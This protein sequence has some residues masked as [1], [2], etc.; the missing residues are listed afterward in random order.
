MGI[1]SAIFFNKLIDSIIIPDPCAYHYNSKI[2]IGATFKMFYDINSGTG[3][4]PEPSDFN[5]IFTLVTGILLG[6]ILII[7]AK[8]IKKNVLQQ[9]V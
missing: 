4:H 2:E 9:G 7:I 5:I 8:R 3:Y 6:V 1:I